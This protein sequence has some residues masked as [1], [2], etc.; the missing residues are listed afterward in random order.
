MCLHI[1]TDLDGTL[2]RSDATLSPYTAR[3]VADAIKQ[4]AVISYATA[5][6]YI[7]SN[8]V[9]GEIPWKYPI[10]LY[11]GAVML[12]PVT[13]EVLDGAWLDGNLANELIGVGQSFGFT[14]FL[15]A[16]N[17]NDQEMVLHEKLSRPGDRQFYRS[18]PGDPRF[19]EM[20]QLRCPEDFRTLILTYIGLLEELQPLEAA[21]RAQFSERLHIHL[22]KDNYIPE[23]YF[24]EFSHPD[25]SKKT[26]LLKWAQYVGCKP[27]DVIVFGDNLNDTGMFEAAGTRVAV[28]NAHPMLFE[29]ATHQTDSNDHD[30]VALFIEK[31]TALRA[32]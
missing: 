16:L 9:A 21:I 28:A 4:G 20:E 17:P 18:R 12:D 23:H 10:L 31:M 30:G 5:R 6:S 2:L 32:E 14:P 27:E 26:G 8:R 19:T 1:L 24:L 29:L 11:N 15:F 7:S 22:M 25:G 13:K 3:T